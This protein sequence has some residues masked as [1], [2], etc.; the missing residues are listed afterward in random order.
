MA[1]S[2]TTN[3]KMTV[4]ECAI[5]V[6]K[7]CGVYETGETPS[8]DDISHV[9]QNMNLLLQMWSEEGLRLWMQRTQDVTLTAS[10][11]TYSL[12]P[13]GADITMP[14]PLQIENCLRKDS[15]NIEVPLK[16][17]SRNEYMSLPNKEEEGTPINVYY[18]PQRTS[19]VL[20]VYLVPDTAA[21]A[22]YTLTLD[23]R[24]PIDDL[25]GF[26]NDIEIPPAWFMALKW[27]TAKQCRVHFDVPLEVGH[28]IAAEAREAYAMLDASDTEDGTSL[29]FGFGD[30]F[31][32]Y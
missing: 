16:I 14:R 21:A 28:I 12:G 2:G 19:G 22:E 8:Y 29:T 23:Y 20:Y 10:K 17:W 7:E 15:D 4:N 11:R 9:M 26:T 5:A 3:F 27:N 30:E 25:T 18:D 6:L 13:S 1:L 32:E 31:E 24:K